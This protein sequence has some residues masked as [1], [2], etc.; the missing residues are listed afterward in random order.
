[1]SGETT[2]L[3]ALAVEDPKR[4]AELVARLRALGVTRIG[5]LELGPLPAEHLARHPRT[6]DRP[7][8]RK[9]AEKVH[10]TMFAASSIRPPLPE[11][12]P[13]TGDAPRAVVQR[14]AR[15]E[16]DGHGGSE[17]TSS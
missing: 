9:L 13:N 16:G 10:A 6:T 11:V 4:F 1:M 5:D 8:P 7:E 15:D 3:S 12:T 14:R 2:L 17:G